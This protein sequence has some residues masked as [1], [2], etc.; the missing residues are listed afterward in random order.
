MTALLLL[1]PA[2]PMLFQGQEFGSTSCF[3]YFADHHDDLAKLVEKGREEFLTQFP[4]VA[5]PETRELLRKPDAEDTFMRSKLCFAER[6]RHAETYAMHRDL[7]RLRREDPVFSKPRAGLLDGAVLSPDAFVLRYFGEDGEHR[8][9]LVNLG[10]DLHLHPAPEPLLAP[11]AGCGWEL[12]WSSEDPRYG[13]AGTPLPETEEN[14][15]ILGHA[16]LV[17]RPK[18]EQTLIS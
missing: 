6:E 13:G 2:T 18:Q 5:R 16:A 17:L 4:S 14:W 1:L 7:L 15:R 9:L 10:R 12:L 11:L 8:L 3:H